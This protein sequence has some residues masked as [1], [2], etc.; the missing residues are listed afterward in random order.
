MVDKK[1][2]EKGHVIIKYNCSSDPTLVVGETY[3]FILD[4]GF[5]SHETVAVDLLI[6]QRHIDNPFEL[7]Y[8]II[9]KIVSDTKVVI[10]WLNKDNSR[11]DHPAIKRLISI[12]KY[13]KI[14]KNNIS[15][16][17]EVREEFCTDIIRDI[18]VI[19]Y[20]KS[21]YI[22]PKPYIGGDS[23]CIE[24]IDC[25]NIEFKDIKY[26]PD[27]QGIMVVLL[28]RNKI[29]MKFNTE[30]VDWYGMDFNGYSLRGGCQIS[31]VTGR[32]IKI[33]RELDLSKELAVVLRSEA[34]WI[35]LMKHYIEVIRKTDVERA[36]WIQGIL[37]KAL[38]INKKFIRPRLNYSPSPRLN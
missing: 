37:D 18:S 38:K 10:D 17:K 33:K 8:D 23:I 6:E 22:D 12:F 15:E 25:M 21:Y 11:W 2:L 32:K 7:V 14:Y 19:S 4:S 5:G 1:E 26:I 20:P 27:C 29:G 34:G 28:G 13:D 31:D 16:L 35:N 36:D 9:S 30:K 24:E 3:P